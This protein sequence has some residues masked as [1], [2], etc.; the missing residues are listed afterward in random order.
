[1]KKEKKKTRQNRGAILIFMLIGVAC[2]LVMSAFTQDRL[3]DFGVLIGIIFQLSLFA[4]AYFI[5]L[6]VHEG[7]HLVAGLL[8]GYGFGSFRVG[9]LMLIKENGKMKLKKHS[10]AGTGGQC[11]MT[12][13]KSNDVFPVIF[14]NLGGVLLNIL[15]IPLSV[16]LAR[17]FYEDDI[18]YVFFVFGALSA[19][20]VF[21][22]NGIP[23]KLG[24]INNDGAN[25]L[26]LYK[27][28]ESRRF[29]HYQ[30]KIVEEISRGKRIR[31]MEDEIFP[32][33]SEEGMQMSIS[34][35]GAVFLENRLID[36]GRLDEALSLIDKLIY[37]KNA[38]IG[39]HKNLLRCDKI[40][41]LLIMGERDEA[42]RFTYE[43]QEYSLFAKQM[44]GNIS[45]LRTEYAYELLIKRDVN[46]AR[47]VLKR[48]E[49]SAK[50]HPYVTEIDSERELIALID[51]RSKQINE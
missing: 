3:D 18:F 44:K 14:F 43:S 51:E 26:E 45:I 35:S 46:A 36:E 34:A 47:A 16:L 20:I 39:L 30:L 41:L 1:V 28:E 22:T 24:M 8:S 4:A 21:L 29:F 50:T 38:L 17:V 25:A 10:V 6:I 2:G 37:G 23:L 32:M 19:F 48:F 31:D 15:S 11:L 7:G 49:K 9:N 42:A 12:P 33:P 27:S 13:P 40:A 5:Q